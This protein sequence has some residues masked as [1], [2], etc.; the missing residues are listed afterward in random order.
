MDGA[1]FSAQQAELG[2]HALPYGLNIFPIQNTGLEVD[3]LL[4]LNDLNCLL[5]KSAFYETA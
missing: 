3:F 4:A 5:F 1:D 2:N